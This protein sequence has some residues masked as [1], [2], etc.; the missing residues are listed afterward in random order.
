MGPGF[1]R[2][3]NFNVLPALKTLRFRYYKGSGSQA[4]LVVQDH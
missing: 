3:D 1:R 4:P 2:D